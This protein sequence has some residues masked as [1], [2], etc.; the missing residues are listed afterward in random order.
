MIIVEI[1]RFLVLKKL[2]LSEWTNNIGRIK[3]IH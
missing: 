2:A 3:N 1:Q